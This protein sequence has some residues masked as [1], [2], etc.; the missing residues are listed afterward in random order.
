MKKIALPLL[1]FTFLLCS[2]SYAVTYSWNTYVAGALNY[3]NGNM[4]SVITGTGFDTRGPQDPNG[5]SN[6]GYKSPKYV[7]AATI[8]TYQGGFTSDYGM[9]GLV[10][11]HDWSNLATSTVVAITF[12]S[13]VGGPVSFNIYDINTGSWGGNN[14]VWIDKVTITGTDCAGQAIYPVITGCANNVSGTNNNIVTGNLNCTNQTNTVTFNSSSVKTI[15]LTYSSGSPL[16]T[17]YGTDPDPQYIII[18]DITTGTWSLLNI[19]SSNPTISCSSSSVTLSAT[20][21]VGAA[22][23]SWAG[24]N[25]SNQ[26]GTTPNASSTNVNATGTY[27]VTATDPGSGCSA[28]ASVAVVSNITPPGASINSPATLTCSN[29]SV[30]LTASSP[31]SGVNYVWNGGGAGSANNV[32]TGG[33]YTVTVTNP[34]NSCTSTASVSV[35]QNT[36]VPN[37]GIQPPASLS[38]SNTTVTVT[39]TS[40]TPNATYSWSGGGTGATKNVT[41]VGVYTV[42]VTDP[43]NGCT[44]SASTQVSGSTGLTISIIPLAATCGQN[45]GSA[46]ITVVSGTA[47]GYIWSNGDNTGTAAN[48]QAGSYTVTVTGAGSCSATASVTITGTDAPTFSVSSVNATCG[49]SNGSA[50]V[51]V[52]SGNVTGYTWS[53]GDNTATATNLAAGNYTVTITGDNSCSASATVAVGST[54]SIAVSALA[55]NT[56]CGNNNGSVT[57]SVITGT[58][59]GYLWSNGETTSSINNLSGGT[60]SVT[61]NDNTGC[62]ATSSA[63]VNASTLTPVTITANQTVFCASDSAKVCAPPGYV[64]YLWNTGA[65]DSCISAKLAGNYYL[66]VTDNN[67]CTIASNHL[68]ITVHPLP[69]VSISV[70]GDTLSAYN[71]VTYQ[72]YLNGNL[73]P[74]ATSGLYITKQPGSYTVLV[75]DA[76]GCTAQSLPVV[77]NVTGIKDI[78]ETFVNVYPNPLQDGNWNL[79]ADVSLLGSKVEVFDADGRLIYLGEMLSQKLLVPANIQRGIYMLHIS[80]ERV[81][82]KRKLIKL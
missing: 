43:A 60:Y 63:F 48:L 41:T 72:W 5:G 26:A 27:T 73:I 14:P 20:S 74:G 56:T 16:A 1:V 46:S 50:S 28:S 10:I 65:T 75:S 45:N 30:V 79:D 59:T 36:T 42:T 24:P 9:P 19:T 49:N 82:I 81:S 68:A 35:S 34:A 53:S 67:Q 18:S 47:T 39:A 29:T 33:T 66:T 15:T 77:V 71:S 22:T 57:T 4:T 17:G 55:V 32:T 40:T 3:T 8:N 23:Y 21:S 51:A 31:T 37:A 2:V 62:S 6:N 12:A 11:G 13:P 38:C 7:S 58:A 76:N 64:S 69:P 61:V 52:I 80:N 25:S 78:A 54:G 44:A 70:T